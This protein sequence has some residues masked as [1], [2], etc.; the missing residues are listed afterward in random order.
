MSIDP[1]H[2]ERRRD[3][4][5]DADVVWIWIAVILMGLGGLISLIPTKRAAGI[6]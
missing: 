5:Q 1:E 6:V 2:A 3:R 4:H